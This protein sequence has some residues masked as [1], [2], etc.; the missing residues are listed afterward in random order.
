MTNQE[1]MLGMPSLTGH[2][3]SRKLLFLPQ[4]VAQRLQQHG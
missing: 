1:G 2:R 4:I 3:I